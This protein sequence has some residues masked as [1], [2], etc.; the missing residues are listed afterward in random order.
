MKHNK[1]FSKVYSKV[2]K[3]TDENVCWGRVL[4]IL[5]KKTKDET[6]KT[7]CDNN[8]KIWNKTYYQQKYKKVIKI[9]PYKPHL[10]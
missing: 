9:K 8:R 6:K 1:C 7:R 4:L 10:Q 5:S 2:Y 3:I